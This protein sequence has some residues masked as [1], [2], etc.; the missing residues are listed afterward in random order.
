[1]VYHVKIQRVQGTAYW[2]NRSLDQLFI[3]LL[4]PFVNGQVIPAREG[5]RTTLINMRSVTFAN[6]YKTEQ[7]LAVP[8]GTGVP[9]PM[10]SAD[11]EANECTAELLEAIR[12]LQAFPTTSTLQKAFAP[13][14]NQVFVIMK[15]GDKHL[16]SAYGGVIKPVIAEFGMKALRIDEVQDS[17]RIT[18]QALE[19]IAT[20]RFVLADLSGE[21]PNC[22]Y[23]AGFAHALGKTLIFTI[24]KDDPIHFDLADYRFI[25]WET[26]AELRAALR[27]RLRA[28]LSTDGSLGKGK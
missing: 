23:E 17:G 4:I 20:S 26:E 19:R 25:R 2:W 8:E 13:H 22:Y 24:R 15:F 3:Q 5:D 6:F 16:D 28:L 12:V 1:M 21:R 14:Q 18:E 10:V 9:A 27:E 7:E 11:F